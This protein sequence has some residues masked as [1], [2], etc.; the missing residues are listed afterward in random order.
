MHDLIILQLVVDNSQTCMAGKPAWNVQQHLSATEA[1]RRALV[2][3][4]TLLAGFSC[5]AGVTV[6]YYWL[7]H[8]AFRHCSAF[9]QN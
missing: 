4:R 7:Q 5:H 2:G 6:F 1:A 9:G 3:C 8:V